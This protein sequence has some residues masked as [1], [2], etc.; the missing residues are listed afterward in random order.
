MGSHNVLVAWYGSVEDFGTIGDLLSVQTVINHLV[1][2]GYR[3]SHATSRNNFDIKGEQVDWRR[4]SPVFFD[5]FIFVCGPILKQHPSRR[6]FLRNSHYVRKL[7]WVSV[8]C[9]RTILITT[10]PLIT[11]WQGKELRNHSRMLQSLLQNSVLTIG[12]GTLEAKSPSACRCVDR[13][14][15]TELRH[16]FQSNWTRPLIAPLAKLKPGKI[17]VLLRTKITC[18]GRGCRR[19]KFKINIGVAISLSRRDFTGA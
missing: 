8:C 19:A 11:F 6:N 12:A 2:T 14:M 1:G 9:Q 13:R 16:V 7:L 5:T 18:K 3:V 4:V 10:I 15:N 17:L